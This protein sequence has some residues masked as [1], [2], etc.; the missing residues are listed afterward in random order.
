MQLDF[1]KIH[2]TGNDFIVVDDLSEE[3]ELTATQV[4]KL[5]DR[6][7][8][9]GADGVILVRPSKHAD[10]T[11]Y[12]H[13]I[14][15]DGSLAEMC[16]NGV[17][18]FAKFLVDLGFVNLKEGERNEA[19]ERCGFFIA[20]TK[21]GKRPVHFTVDEN[22]RL[23]SATVNM[24]EPRF[25]PQDI[26]TT[27]PATEKTAIAQPDGTKVLEDVVHLSGN[28]ASDMVVLESGPVAGFVDVI[29]A[30]RLS[31]PDIKSLT[32]V[33][34]GNPHLVIFLDESVD[35]SAY[36]IALPGALLEK[37]A[38]L[39][40]EGTNVEFAIL[41]PHMVC[42]EGIVLGSD[43]SAHIQMRVWERGCGETLACGT[44]ACATAVAAA[45][46][47]NVQRRAVVHLPG[48]E[49]TVEWRLD[50]QVYLTGPAQMVFQ[51]SVEL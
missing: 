30:A 16:G 7:F 38:E 26:P 25:A 8:G 5:C 28:M 44:G 17:R 47:E 37:N 50:N 36:E 49:L 14:N 2:G 46:F 13:Y 42:G 35:L 12:M 18:C 23:V 11:A 19:G 20:D 39:F 34:M 22:G 3:I 1:I 40:P 29:A 31:L 15:S 32:C 21:A 10:C 51:G 33:S 4:Q 24:G 41:A 45:V 6:H 27:M 48:G 9:I 43:D